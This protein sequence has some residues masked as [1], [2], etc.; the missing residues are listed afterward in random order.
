MCFKCDVEIVAEL[1]PFALSRGGD[2]PSILLLERVVQKRI[3]Q[4]VILNRADCDKE[5][6]T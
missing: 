6:G 4:F 1:L 5:G 2:L 3:L